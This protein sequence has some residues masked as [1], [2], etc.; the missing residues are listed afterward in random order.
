MTLQIALTGINAA[1]TE[2]E[3]ISN[4]I[5]N[6]ATTGFKRARVEFADLYAISGGS[7]KT[8]TGQG[9]GAS[10][11]RQ[12]FTQGGLETTNRNLDL[13]VQGLGMFRLEGNSQISY[14]RAGNFGMD[15]EGHLV[16]SADEKLTG[17]SV[18]ADDELE[19]FLSTL[20]VDFSDIP[21]ED[22]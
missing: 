16:N 22:V 15:E 19:P 6:N 12:D 8:Q 9:V 13:A 17:Y 2:L 14:T 21:P 7:S 1:S 20:K 4:N 18:N 5:A 3:N 11:V 10:N